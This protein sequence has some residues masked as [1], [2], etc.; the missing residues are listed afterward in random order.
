[1]PKKYLLINPPRYEVVPEYFNVDI[2]AQHTYLPA[3]LLRMG[4]YFKSLGDKVSLINCFPTKPGLVVPFYMIGKRRC[5][6]FKDK[7]VFS[8]LY[9]FGITYEDFTKKLM[10]EEIPD[11]IYVTSF[12]TYQWEAVHQIIRICKEV[13]PTTRVTLGGIYPTLSPR[14]AETSLAD[15]VYS[16]EF[17][18]SNICRLDLDLLG[19]VPSHIV[20]KTSRGC[21][22]RCSYCAVSFLEGSKM[23]YRSPVDVVE[24]IEEKIKNFNIR[25][26]I[27]W[28]SN[29]L[30]NSKEHLEPLLDLI[31]KKGL[32]L[33]L[34]FPEGF[35]P[36]FLTHELLVKMKLAGVVLLALS[37]ETSSEALATE[38]FRSVH[39]LASFREKA[40]I[41]KKLN[42]DCVG[43]VMAG[44]PG[45]DF[46]SVKKTVDDV[47]NAGI[48]PLIMPFTPIPGTK[49][50]EDCFES[51]AEKGLEDLHP[52]LWPCVDDSVLYDNLCRLHAR[53]LRM[54]DQRPERTMG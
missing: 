38:R 54:H 37:L 49:E 22:G 29:I 27:F 45:Q 51:I 1:M 34:K 33:S 18:V 9:H 14:H 20:L 52:Y 48:I 21:P 11:E 23:R 28:E 39:K 7:E 36:E 10:L 31:I 24:E 3:A 2:V 30:L 12:F 17:P 16:G 32:K 46:G 26:I 43:F 8:P 53:C 15:A 42:I 40:K 4:S 47:L 50:Y 25:E 19:D 41:I 44:M 5:G 35:N 6:N 13:F